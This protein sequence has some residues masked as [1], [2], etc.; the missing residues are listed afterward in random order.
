MVVGSIITFV[1]SLLIGGI[2]IYVGAKIIADVED[3]PYALITALIG[4]ILWG[5]IE[6]FVP[7]IGGLVAFIAYLWIINRRYP[8]GWI[9]AILITLIAWIAVV[10]TLVIL[11]T[12]G[13]DAVGAYGVPG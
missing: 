8:G 7:I 4:G 2:G 10:V 12:I 3:F 11:S 6:F 5:I 1:V 13:L 9:E